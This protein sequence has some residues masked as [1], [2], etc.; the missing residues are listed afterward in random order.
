MTFCGCVLKPGK[1]ERVNVPDGEV[2]HLSQV[3]VHDPKPGKNYVQVEVKGTAYTLVCLEKDKVEHNSL[4]LFFGPEDAV[5][6]TS[7]KSE[8]H[9]LGYLEPM[10]DGGD[11]SGDDEDEEE[12][13][14]EG[15][16]AST[17]QPAR[18]P[19]ATSQSEA[20]E[21]LAR[22]AKTEKAELA[23]APESRVPR[24]VSSPAMGA[25]MP[26]IVEEELEL[27]PR[28]VPP[29]AVGAPMPGIV[30]EDLQLGEAVEHTPPELPPQPAQPEPKLPSLQPLEPMVPF[31]E[32]PEA[33][34]TPSSPA[35]AS[36]ESEEPKKGE[37]QEE[38]R[39]IL[40]TDYDREE[41]V[42]W[43][44]FFDEM[45]GKGDHDD[46]DDQFTPRSE[47]T[48]ASVR[49][50]EYDE[51]QPNLFFWSNQ[52]GHRAPTGGAS[53]A[54]PLE[55]AVPVVIIKSQDQLAIESIQKSIKEFGIAIEEIR[56]A[57]HEIEEM[58]QQPSFQNSGSRALEYDGE[59]EDEEA[60]ERRP[61]GV[62]SLLEK[63]KARLPV[64]LEL[65]LVST[66]GAA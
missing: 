12:E 26:R 32:P 6:S 57:F 37:E 61:L 2:W 47:V 55:E 53:T 16:A 30:E 34:V 48:S 56:K 24:A 52:A 8:V 14:E 51:D 22:P 65:R 19:R 27:V 40:V 5:F 35:P 1:K 50:I 18:E 10:D 41:E 42:D 59:D 44:E 20:E 62:A 25:P 31:H 13:E 4:D 11:M 46:D 9:L 17:A 43:D 15:K 7:G 66:C 38:R 54:T 45:E 64:P 58:L 21:P 28:A 3:C 49:E 29:P 39:E 23:Q 36:P 63:P 60:D 33:K